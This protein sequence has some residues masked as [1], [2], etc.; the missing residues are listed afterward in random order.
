MSDG[1]FINEGKPFIVGRRVVA[2]CQA[3]GKIVRLDKPF[4]GSLHICS[5]E[6]AQEADASRRQAEE[7]KRYGA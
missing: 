6:R 5:L 1:N 3:C 7:N 2:Q 4:L